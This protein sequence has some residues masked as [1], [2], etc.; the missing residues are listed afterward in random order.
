MLKRAFFMPR[1]YSR[2]NFRSWPT[3]RILKPFARM[4]LN[5]W[6]TSAWLT[7]GLLLIVSQP[8]SFQP[9]NGMLSS[10]AF[11]AAAATGKK[12]CGMMI[13]TPL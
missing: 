10:S 4:S 9:N 5:H 7:V 3:E 11:A 6:T 2:Q 1:K 8:S 13:S 12:A